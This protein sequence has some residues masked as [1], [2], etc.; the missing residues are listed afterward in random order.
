[1]HSFFFFSASILLGHYT[2]VDLNKFVDWKICLV[3]VFFRGMLFGFSNSVNSNTPKALAYFFSCLPKSA[4]YAC[5]LKES[6]S[7][8]E[9]PSFLR[10]NYVQFF[11]FILLVFI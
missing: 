11:Y 5:N 1:M 7:S 8:T 10:S 6:T 3:V 2:H 4:T 9:L